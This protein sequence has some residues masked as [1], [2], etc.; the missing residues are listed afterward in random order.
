MSAAQ[1]LSAALSGAEVDTLIALVEQ[2]PLW[3][4]DVPS[5]SG[6]DSLLQKGLA[7]RIVVNGADGYQAATYAG[8]D[9]Y[10]ARYPS[11]D[12]AADTIG[13][14]RVNRMATRAINA[15]KATGS[16]LALMVFLFSAWAI[17]EGQPTD[18]EASADVA[19]EVEALAVESLQIEAEVEL[20]ARQLCTDL[21]GDRAQVLRLVE[22]HLVCRRRGEVL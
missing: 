14:A 9:A 3:D 4:G 2:G 10:K 6:R 20:M 21:H 22:G 17:A 1:H 19:A 18:T 16:A 8:R 7:V 11:A 13:E 12:S 5:K 15:A